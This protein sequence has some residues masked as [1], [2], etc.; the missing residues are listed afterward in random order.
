METTSNLKRKNIRW[1][2]DMVQHLINSLLEYKRLMT[3]KDLDF[4][5]NKPCQ[6]IWKT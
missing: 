2:N 1:Y 4:N 3:Y 5:A 6:K